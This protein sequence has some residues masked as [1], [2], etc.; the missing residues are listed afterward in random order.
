MIAACG[1]P[2]LSGPSTGDD[3]HGRF[4]D[5]DR[6]YR[7][8]ATDYEACG[9]HVHIGVPD[10]ETAVAVMNHLRPWLPSLLALS[11]NSPFD[12]GRDTCYG[13]WRA[14]Q[15]SR[16][17]G[18]G[19]PPHFGDLAAYRAEVC[20]LVDCGALVDQA[21]SFWL[22]RPSS[23]FPTLEFRVADAASTVDE[24]LLQ[25][26]LSRA[27]VRRAL[28]D[29]AEGIAPPAVSDQVAAAALWAASRD[30]IEGEGVHAVRARRMPA[31][32]LVDELVEHVALAL[33]ETGDR[34]LVAVVLERLRR[35]G[36]GARR[37]RKAAA[38]G[39]PALLATLTHQG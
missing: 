9:C 20:R 29:L 13:S 6:L 3:Q 7:G 39:L 34:D 8:M 22:V 2:V 38:A 10:A 26:V 17:P 30:G 1:T 12:R 37:Q 31:W 14:V 28:R 16:F 19:L 25:A 11:V 15:Q 5:I 4:G 23:S 35:E 32:Q 18:A 33:T 24:T 21:M 36:S 27:L